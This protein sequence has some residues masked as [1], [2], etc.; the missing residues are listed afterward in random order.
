MKERER[1]RES[2]CVCVCVCVCV[3]SLDTQN[4]RT[5]DPTSQLR[6]GTRLRKVMPESG[7]QGG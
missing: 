5:H 4:V 7:G 6:N 3:L 2:V 1:E